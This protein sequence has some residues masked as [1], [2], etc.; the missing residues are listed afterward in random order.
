MHR[1]G[2]A[3]YQAA[4]S[5][6][7]ERRYVDPNGGFVTQLLELQRELEGSSSDPHP[8]PVGVTFSMA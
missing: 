2:L 3:S 8:D 7:R 5:Y 1:R 6:L 4:L